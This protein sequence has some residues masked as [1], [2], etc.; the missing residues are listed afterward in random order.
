[1]GWNCHCHTKPDD[2]PFASWIC[3]QLAARQGRGQVH[4]EHPLQPIYHTRSS[5][6]FVSLNAVQDDWRSREIKQN[7]GTKRAQNYGDLSSWTT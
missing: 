2:S 6:L 7:E 3:L 1:M 4:V 5:N